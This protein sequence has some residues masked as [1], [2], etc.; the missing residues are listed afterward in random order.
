[1]LGEAECRG[2]RRKSRNPRGEEEPGKQWQGSAPG[3]LA[4]QTK[5]GKS[6]HRSTFSSRSVLGNRGLLCSW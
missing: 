2:V 3:L 1:M 4:G 6:E 5:A